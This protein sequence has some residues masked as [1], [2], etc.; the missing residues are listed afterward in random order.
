MTSLREAELVEAL[1]D[2][3][4]AARKSCNAGQ[5]PPLADALFNADLL[6][7]AP[8][9]KPETPTRARETANGWPFHAPPL[10]GDDRPAWLQMSELIDKIRLSDSPWRQRDELVA[11]FLWAKYGWSTRNIPAKPVTD[12]LQVAGGWQIRSGY[13]QHDGD[14]DGR[15]YGLAGY[16]YAE[17]PGDLR[18]RTN[19]RALLDRIL[20]LLDVYDGKQPTRPMTAA[21]CIDWRDKDPDLVRRLAAKAGVD[22]GGNPLPSTADADRVMMAESQTYVADLDPVV[23]V[24]MA[25]DD[26]RPFYDAAQM[27]AAFRHGYDY[28]RRK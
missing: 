11:M 7:S 10:M 14:A 9:P 27:R 22:L 26:R 5:H 6:I 19:D 23:T 21:D 3:S 4:K 20:V 25:P 28:A 2:L 13:S 12:P 18:I 17:G 8:T 1:R 24:Q 16:H 15:N